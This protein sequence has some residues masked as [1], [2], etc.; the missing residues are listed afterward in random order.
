MGGAGNG[1][2]DVNSEGKQINFSMIRLIMFHVVLSG[3]K[4]LFHIDTFQDWLGNC[5]SLTH[6]KPVSLCLLL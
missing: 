4:E 3:T 6:C 5:K 2:Q 1:L